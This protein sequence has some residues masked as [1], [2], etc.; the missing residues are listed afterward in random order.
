MFPGAPAPQDLSENSRLS[1]LDDTHSRSLSHKCLKPKSKRGLR[2]SGVFRS[3][4]IFLVILCAFGAAIQADAQVIDSP[5]FVGQ[6]TSITRNGSNQL[7]ISY[8]DATNDD[9]K[10]WVDDGF[11]A[12]IAGDEL[13]NGSEIRT[14]D[15]AGDVGRDTSITAN[16]AGQL[17]IAYQDYT[18]RDLKVW[19]DD[20]AGGGTA[21]DSQFNGGEIRVIHTAGTTGLNPTVITDSNGYLAVSFGDDT[22][23][24]IML[25]LDNGAGGGVAGDG[26]VNGSELKDIHTAP[27]PRYSSLTLDANGRLALSF[28][29]SNYSDLMVW[30]DDGSG[31][32]TAGDG[33]A[34]GA[35]VRTV[36]TADVD[37]YLSIASAA[38]ISRDAAGNL[39]VAF[40]EDEY[41]YYYYLKL[42][43]DDGAGRGNCRRSAGQRLRGQRHL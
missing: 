23:D 6:Y 13:P 1:T 33:V 2:Q 36:Y 3:F 28:M 8:Y 20:G 25:W 4:E 37:N 9:L 21:G 27:Y 19:I 7:A 35:E 40:I 41:G 30:V 24:D 26:I 14:I 15:T 5:G 31:G 43:V 10:L 29:R 17:A 12:G 39:A 18:N 42:W 34:N 22:Q 11:G 32:G 16:A 38:G